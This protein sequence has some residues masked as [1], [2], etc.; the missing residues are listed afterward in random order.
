[1]KDSIVAVPF[2]NL[3]VVFLVH[4]KTMCKRRFLFQS[5][6]VI[7]ITANTTTDFLKLYTM[8]SCSC[9]ESKFS[10]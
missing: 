4:Y 9:L 1:M 5:Y 7:Q 2:F 10:L 8:P 3:F 6:L